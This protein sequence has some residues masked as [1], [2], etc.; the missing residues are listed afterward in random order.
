MGETKQ[1][2]KTIFLK[3]LLAGL[4]SALLSYFIAFPTA[5][6]IVRLLLRLPIFDGFELGI[7]LVA[8]TLLLITFPITVFL[9]FLISYSILRKA[10][11]I[12]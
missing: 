7:I 3:S 9:F 5:R 2:N 12:E 8:Y 11:K 4:I 1:D 10:F 6:V